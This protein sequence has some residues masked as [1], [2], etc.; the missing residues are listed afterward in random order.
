MRHDVTLPTSLSSLA[1]EETNKLN[2][3]VTIV[4]MKKMATAYIA[5]LISIDWASLIFLSSLAITAF[6]KSIIPKTIRTIG[7][8]ICRIGIKPFLTNLMTA[9]KS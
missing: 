8:P 2:T 6:P 1:P 9:D 7:I 5:L 3:N 4:T